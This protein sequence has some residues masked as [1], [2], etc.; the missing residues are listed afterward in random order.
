MMHTFISSQIS[1]PLISSDAKDIPKTR[2]RGPL[3]E[4]FIKTTRIQTLS[5]G[6]MYF[7]NE[8]IKQEVENIDDSGFLSWATKVALDTLRTGLDVVPTL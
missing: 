8:V 4:V 1:S 3:E 2:N 5:L 6:L 7:F